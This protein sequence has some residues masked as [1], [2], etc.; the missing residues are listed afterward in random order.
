MFCRKTSSG[1]ANLAQSNV[2]THVLSKNIVPAT[3]HI[4]PFEI[5]KLQ[6]NNGISPQLP[7][8]PFSLLD[9]AKVMS[10][11]G[12]E[13]GYLPLTNTHPHKSRW[14]AGLSLCA[15]ALALLAGF[16]IGFSFSSFNRLPEYGLLL[17]PDTSSNKTSTE[18]ALAIDKLP[19]ST[20][21]N[22]TESVS[23]EALRDMIAHTKGYWARDYSLH[24]GWN[25]VSYRPPPILNTLSRL[26]YHSS[27]EVYY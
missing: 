19:V 17:P 6:S 24:L 18:G 8:F 4:Y 16:V 2:F 20:P 23:L 3:C 13:R 27:D 5:N 22:N 1:W 12:N 15:L 10:R 7:M 11:G 25:N 9:R 21:N 26:S 14:S